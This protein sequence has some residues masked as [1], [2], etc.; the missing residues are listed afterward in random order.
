MYGTSIMVLLLRLCMVPTPTAPVLQTSWW[1]CSALEQL[2]PAT[3]TDEEEV[4]PLPVTAAGV[5]AK[6]ELRDN[7][8]RDAQVCVCFYHSLSSL[9]DLEMFSNSERE[10]KKISF[11]AATL[12]LLKPTR[13]VVVCVN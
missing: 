13:F 9:Y 7:R 3:V 5:G 10:R 4:V 12:I 8:G 1:R 2:Q 11:F 6:S